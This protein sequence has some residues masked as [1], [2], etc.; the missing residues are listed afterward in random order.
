MLSSAGARID[1]TAQP[2]VHL[3]RVALQQKSP[4]HAARRAFPVALTMHAIVASPEMSKRR[5]CMAEKHGDIAARREQQLSRRQTSSTSPY[6]MLDRFAD[7]IDRM[8]DQ[9]GF[10]RLA[11]RRGESPDFMTWTPR[12]DVAQRNNEL[13]IRADLPGMH[14]DDVKVDVSDDAVIIQGERR[15]EHEEDQGGVF[16]SERRYGSFQ[17]VIPLPEGADTANAKARFDNGVLEVTVPVPQEGQGSQK[18][19]VE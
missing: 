4:F 10:G 7:E 14:K 17:R 8:F 3:T 12:V 15:R 16:R 11:G 13:V 19:R 6:W 18:I 9:F 1:F 2:L 5:I